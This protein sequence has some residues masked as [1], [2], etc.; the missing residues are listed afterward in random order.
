MERLKRKL[1][2]VILT[3]SLVFSLGSISV[4]ATDIAFEKEGTEPEVVM[5]TDQI[6]DFP[7]PASVTSLMAF[8]GDGIRNKDSE[9]TFT[10]SKTKK[11]KVSH[12]TSKW[13]DK[14]DLTNSQCKMTISLLKKGSLGGYN[15]TGDKF[16]LVG[17]GG[18]Q[19]IYT[20]AAG[21]YRLHFK[22]SVT[23]Q[24]GSQ[25]YPGANINGNVV[26]DF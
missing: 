26:T 13:V 17:V 10:L 22:V 8:A 20:K 18:K 12:S 14:G 1:E 19:V 6:T 24:G 15:D 21:T 5:E 9:H 16:S 3:L 2:L 4:F 11:I 7:V 23:K 25:Y